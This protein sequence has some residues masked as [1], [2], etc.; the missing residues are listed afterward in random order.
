[1]ELVEICRQ[2]IEQTDIA[3]NALPTRCF[4]RALDQAGRIQDGTISD[5]GSGSWLGG[6]PI[7]IKDNLATAFGHTACGSRILADFVPEVTATA[8]ARLDR[9]GALDIARLNM[10]EFAL[11]TTGHNEITGAVRNPWNPAHVTGGSSSGPG[12]AVA[13]RLVY[14]AL[15]SDTGGSIR[16]PAA[17]CGLVGVKP[18]F[19]RVSRHGAMPLSFT[20]DTVGPLARGVADAALILQTIAGP[21]PN[22]PTTGSE[23]VPDYLSDLEAGVRGLR[24][25]TPENYFYDPVDPEVAA[26]AR[27]SLE[28][29]AAL[30]AEIVPVEMPASI[31]LGNPLTMLILAVE[32]AAFHGRW[33][34]QR[35]ADYGRQTLGRLLPGLLYPAKRYVE[36]LSL[37]RKVV[38]ELREAVFER[39][40]VLHTPVWPFPLPTIEESDLAANPGF[41]EFIAATGHC[42]RPVNYAGLPGVSVPAGFTAN[43]LPCA[44]QLVGRPF[45]E[46]LLLR[47]ARAYERETACTAPAPAL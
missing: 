17:A 47:A 25:A 45:D 11:G 21:D 3:L 9:A 19:G 34:E 44:F 46:A 6:L 4:E 27:A 38:D 22:D 7:A 40:D 10:V 26:L 33:L 35:R 23:P 16:L 41:T 5:D 31:E 36:A 20:L 32:G 8:L 37:R 24:I 28:V 1:M 42:S 14:G 12:A 29:F 39:A 13:A 18:T 2:R 15:G 43:G 30:G